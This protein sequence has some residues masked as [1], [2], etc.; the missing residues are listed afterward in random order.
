[1]NDSSI[2]DVSELEKTY[3]LGLFRR[4]TV[5]ALKGV[6][7]RVDRGEI[8][9]LL[10]PNGAGKTTL[11]K[12]LLGIVRKSRGEAQLLGRP[13]GDRHGRRQVGY[14]PE[15][16]R[17][18][19]HLTANSALEYY[20]GL[21]GLPV[22]RVRELRG[23]LLDLV[24]LG[25]WGKV[26][27]KKFSKGMLQRLGMAQAM[28]HRPKLLILD[29]PTD[30]VDPLGRTQMRE[31]LQKLKADGQTVFLNSHLLQEVE[32]VCDRVAILDKGRLLKVGNIDEI[33]HLGKVD[34]V[35]RLQGDEATVRE[36]L[37][38]RKI[39]NWKTHDDNQLQL[40]VE[41]AGQ[42]ELDASVDSLR[43]AG[44]SIFSM[45]RH[46]PTLEQAFIEIVNQASGDAEKPSFSNDLE[47]APETS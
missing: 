36:A 30:G 42:A 32:L 35:F 17:I 16:H 18:P 13:A 10:G 2:I 46:R 40:E 15:S 9:G 29:E 38:N 34:V 26:G 31:V 24:G 39:V 6:S 23:E 12:I 11:I 7:L 3:R 8:F 25:D 20:G 43:R 21:S 4:K 47:P 14:L 41:A 33:T 37:K 1:M 5:E 45:A 44:V 27:V 22:S 28:L 19:K